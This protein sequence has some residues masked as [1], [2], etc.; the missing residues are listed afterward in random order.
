MNDKCEHSAYWQGN[1]G[2][3]I[4]CRAE[5][6]EAQLKASQEETTA[7]A[8]KFAELEAAEVRYLDVTRRLEEE[9]TALKAE[10][11]RVG[12]V[13]V[14]CAVTGCAICSVPAPSGQGEKP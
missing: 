12:K 11:H 14:G 8:V 3:C 7:L 5:I 4:A 10:L 2:T 6:A 1:Y 13:L 9:N